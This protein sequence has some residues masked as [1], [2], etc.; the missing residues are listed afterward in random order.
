MS[1]LKR[2]DRYFEEVFCV[3]LFSIMVILTFSQVLSRFVFNISLGWSEEISRFMFVWL[4]YLSAAMAA[5]H[6]RHIRVELIDQFLPRRFSKW[7]GLV[8][9]ILW[10]TYALIVSYYGW[11]V[12]MMIMGHGQLSPAVQLPMGWIYMIIPFGYVLIAFRVAQ[13]IVA[14]FRGEDEL[15]EEEK[16]RKVIEEG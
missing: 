5:K 8:S 12:S 11:N 6:R 15:T 16:L 3:V 7:A 9:D 14:R 4:V 2:I 1:L 10:I 13:G